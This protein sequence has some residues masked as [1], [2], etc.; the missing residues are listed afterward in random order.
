MS[1][2]DEALTNG[3]EDLSGGES[4]YQSDWT[5]HLSRAGL[6]GCDSVHPYH[7]IGDEKAPMEHRLISAPPARPPCGDAC[8]EQPAM[9]T[10]AVRRCHL[11]PKLLHPNSCR[12][13]SRRR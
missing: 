9:K 4:V 7:L 6:M 8:C 5:L 10:A 2:L 12:S 3:I 11:I 1:S 13:L